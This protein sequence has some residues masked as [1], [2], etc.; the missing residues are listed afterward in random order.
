MQ[1]HPV[2]SKHN[3]DGEREVGAAFT[4][5]RISAIREW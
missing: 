3:G 5:D 2:L 4:S 1:A